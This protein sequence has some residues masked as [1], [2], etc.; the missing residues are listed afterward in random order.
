ME[1]FDSWKARW[2]NSTAGDVPVLERLHSWS[3]RSQEGPF[4]EHSQNSILKDYAM[5]IVRKFQGDGP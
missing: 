2:R 5:F 3:N 4:V 1:H